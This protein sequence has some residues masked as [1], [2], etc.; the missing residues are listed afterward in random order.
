MNSI[1][2]LNFPVITKEYTL[3]NSFYA[4]SQHMLENTVKN[5]SRRKENSLILL[6]NIDRKFLSKILTLNQVIY[7]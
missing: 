5:G 2:A 7:K 4:A 3:Q 1:S 6:I